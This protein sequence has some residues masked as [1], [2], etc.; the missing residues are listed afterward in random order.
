MGFYE[1]MV[2]EIGYG[3]EIKI[4][5][6]AGQD[7]LSGDLCVPSRK[8]T[9]DMF[10]GDARG[11]FRQEALL[12]HSVEATEQG[13]AL[14]G[15]ERHNVALAFDRPQLEGQR[16]AQRVGSWDHAR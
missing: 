4:E 5:R 6:Q 8:Q 2:A 11:I 14:I 12:R 9:R 15:N 13:E 3:M 1:R 10:G 16:G 7:V